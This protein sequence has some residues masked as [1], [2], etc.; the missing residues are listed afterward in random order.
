MKEKSPKS[1][2]LEKANAAWNMFLC[3]GF[4]SGEE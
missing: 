1:V 2:E 4:A 3:N